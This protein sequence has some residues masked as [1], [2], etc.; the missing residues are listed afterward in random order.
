MKV[1]AYELVDRAEAY[2]LHDENGSRIRLDSAHISYK[3]GA[4]VYVRSGRFGA[5][6]GRDELVEVEY[7]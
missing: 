7:V 5:A 4:L 1:R 3:D 6:F 2:W